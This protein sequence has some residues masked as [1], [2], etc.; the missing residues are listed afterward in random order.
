MLTVRSFILT[1]VTEED[2][3][4]SASAPNP[5]YSHGGIPSD[6]ISDA[7]ARIGD[8]RPQIEPAD[9][10]VNSDH[11]SIYVCLRLTSR[12]FGSAL[13]SC[14]HLVPLWTWSFLDI[15]RGDVRISLC[16]YIE[17]LIMVYPLRFSPAMS[18]L[19]WMG[20]KDTDGSKNHD[21]RREQ[22]GDTT[23]TRNLVT[24]NARESMMPKTPVLA[25][26]R[27]TS[28]RSSNDAEAYVTHQV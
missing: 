14:R 11:T 19:T 23:S 6:L 5:V 22:A 8:P 13:T 17:L 27:T 12:T 20:T 9:F 21:Q 24:Y 1:T 26:S 25:E 28:T 4:S 2:T 3:R 16:Q 7:G 18:I 10:A 15:E